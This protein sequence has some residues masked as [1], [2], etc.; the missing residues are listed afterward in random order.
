MS[1]SVGVFF[2]GAMFVASDEFGV[3][4]YSTGLE[5]DADEKKSSSEGERMILYYI[6]FMNTCLCLCERNGRLRLP[7]ITCTYAWTHAD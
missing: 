3:G 2:V 1:T 6:S 7:F 4:W 5:S